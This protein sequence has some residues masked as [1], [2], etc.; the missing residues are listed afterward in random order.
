MEKVTS[1]LA[2]LL[3]LTMLIPACAFFER[4]G[5]VV[6]DNEIL[7]YLVVSQAT[8]RFIQRADDQPARASKVIDVANQLETTVDGDPTATVD[9]LK[10]L[11]FE[12][13]N[14]DN[15]TPADQLLLF[16]LVSV[17]EKEIL[18]GTETG[19]LNEETKIALKSVLSSV[20]SGAAVFQ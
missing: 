9:T 3:F 7:A 13:V 10:K 20:R 1:K 12:N 6:S 14:L 19:Q 15:L 8:A 4:V 5:T 16:D 18:K 11:V 2:V 17:A